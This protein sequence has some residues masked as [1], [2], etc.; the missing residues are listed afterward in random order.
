MAD[1]REPTGKHLDQL[2]NAYA[3]R[4][5]DESTDWL[6]LAVEAIGAE[7]EVAAAFSRLSL[8]SRYQ[9]LGRLL[10]PLQG[11]L[12]GVV[13]VAL[14]RCAAAIAEPEIR[15]LL[16]DG[17]VR[18]QEAGVILLATRK[19]SLA[20][21]QRLAAAPQLEVAAELA[22][23][24]AHYQAILRDRPDLE[25]ALELESALRIARARR[26]I[27]GTFDI[28]ARKR[29]LET[30]LA[31]AES[32]ESKRSPLEKGLEAAC[33]S[34]EALRKEIADLETTTAKH[35]SEADALKSKRDELRERLEQLAKL[36]RQYE[37]DRERASVDFIAAV[38]A[39][40]DRLTA[41]GVEANDGLQRQRKRLQEIEG[42]VRF[43][44]RTDIEQRIRELIGMFPEDGADRIVNPGRA[45]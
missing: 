3:A 32:L 30:L 28:D 13:L 9:I 33:K 1:T 5:I 20:E 43:A 45:P 25:R 38:A 17:S 42:A 4:S 18:A 22:R 24:E 37:G 44:G 15:Q 8:E 35:E 21:A 29:E 11:P 6:P 36:E 34:A 27:L 14:A 41:S 26:V 12:A 39:I 7:K 31:E 10:D 23:V 2:F 40:C 16:H 19:E